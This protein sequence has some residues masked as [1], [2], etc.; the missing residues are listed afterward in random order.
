MK[1]FLIYDSECLFCQ[2]F[3]FYL[4]RIIKD[5][6]NSI[7]VASSPRKIINY[8]DKNQYNFITNNT[9][10]LE[11]MSKTS[12][13]Y[14]KGNSIYLEFPAITKLFIDS[15]NKYFK[16]IGF[17]LE[18]LIPKFI[19]NIIYKLISKNRI[20][21]SKLLFKEKCQLNF[22]NLKIIN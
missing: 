14:I 15:G 9:Y 21:I 1:R 7:Y 2:R 10:K 19:G 20:H 4:D 8:L 11:H 5:S 22:N 17:L 13:I 6:N 3:L 16:L 12:I 18:I